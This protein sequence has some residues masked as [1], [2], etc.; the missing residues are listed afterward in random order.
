MGLTG[1]LTKFM[2]LEIAASGRV[3]PNLQIR[4]P[5][6]VLFWSIAFWPKPAG[7]PLN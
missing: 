3:V 4:I 7:F 1:V 6:R 5:D 2:A